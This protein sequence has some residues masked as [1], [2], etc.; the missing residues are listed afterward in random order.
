MCNIKNPNR[1]LSHERWRTWQ[2]KA[3]LGN[4]IPTTTYG[5][6]VCKTSQYH[7]PQQRLLP[8]HKSSTF[9][10]S[11]QGAH[12][13]SLKIKWDNVSEMRTSTDFSG[14]TSVVTFCNIWLTIVMRSRKPLASA[15]SRTTCHVITNCD[16]DDEKCVPWHVSTVLKPICA[17]L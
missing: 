7:I 8:T 3:N 9:T 15:M 12:P 10:Y 6:Y 16:S 5:L 4:P 13:F 1:R 2:P 14:M 11:C 17:G